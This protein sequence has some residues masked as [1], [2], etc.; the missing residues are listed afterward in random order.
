MKSPKVLILRSSSGV[1]GAER[2]VLELCKG[3]LDSPFQ[4]VIGVITNRD[5][6]SILLYEAARSEN[7]PAEVFESEGAFDRGAILR[8]REYIETNNVDIINTHGYKAN[9]YAAGAA[10]FSKKIMI[11]TIHPW[12][13]TEY[14]WRSKFYT[15]LDKLVLRMFDERIAVSEN[16]LQILNTQMPAAR[17]ELIPNGIDTSRFA[18]T[19]E[20]TR[21]QMREMLNVPEAGLLIG[22]IG[23]LAPEKGFDVFLEAA[24]QFHDIHPN[25]RFVIVGDGELR[26]ALT[27]KARQLNLQGVLTFTGVRA[28]I[29]ALLSAMDI[30]VLSSFSEGLPMV[31]LEA[32][33]AG[34]AVVAT[35]VGDV[36][37][38]IRNEKTGL[39]VPPNNA[40][41]LATALNTLATSQEKIRQY[42]AAAQQFVRTNYDLK[43]MTERYIERFNFWLQKRETHV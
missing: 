18:Q 34:K 42:G 21:R 36:S 8:L 28:D 30:Y 5:E 3:L 39:L 17:H 2:V 29:P 24:K 26:E 38:L 19:D 1:F 12:T 37:M 15:W 16:V 23:R 6:R 20:A 11:A 27:A 32:M 43:K 7:L 40:A 33:A 4:P 25:S 10:A 41:A 35:S 9:V 14:S 31:V 22:T 13:E